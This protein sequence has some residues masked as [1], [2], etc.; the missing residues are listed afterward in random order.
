MR[1]LADLHIHSCFSRATSRQCT[2]PFLAAWAKVKG[3]DLLGSGDFTH[4]EWLA[5]LRSELEPCE[6]GFHRP[7]SAA[8][9]D[10]MSCYRPTDRDVRFV[11]TTE[12]SCI[13]KQDGAVRKVHHLLAVPDFDAAARVNKR[14]SRIGNLAADGRPILG[15]SSR[16]LLEILLESASDGFLVPAHVW[17]PWFSLFGAKSGFDRI[18]DCFGDLSDQIFALETGL[19]ADPAMMRRISALDRFT[20]VSNSDAHS[21]LKLGRELNRFDTGF[22]FPAM[23]QALQQPQKG[24][25][26][27]T[28]EF[29]PEEGKYY[30]DGH[31]ACHC[32]MTPSQTLQAGGRCPVCGRPLTTGVLSRIASLADRPHAVYSQ[33]DPGFM[34]LLPLAE[35][36]TELG[37]VKTFTRRIQKRFR[38]VV[39][40]FGSELELLLEVPVSDIERTDSA[41]LAEA[42][43]RVRLGDVIREP[44]FDGRY[45]TVRVFQPD[46]S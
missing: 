13:Y 11:L 26:R 44:G 40:R 6:S 9:P 24:G 14:L 32:R 29:F 34:S 19:S 43:N 46:S 31:R 15:L 42:V 41:L 17:T 8:F 10:E 25:F 35:I 36:L 1:Y 38:E 28:I 30:L 20:L 23:K 21:P 3:I 2:L 45:G 18:E 22:D 27:G 7:R 4:P 12:I 33:A 37:G 16:D 5:H 39:N